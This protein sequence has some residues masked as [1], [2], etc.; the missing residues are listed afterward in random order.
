MQYIEN[1][2]IQCL[3]E[4]R[5]LYLSSVGSTTKTHPHQTI[6]TTVLSMERATSGSKWTHVSVAAYLNIFAQSIREL[7]SHRVPTKRNGKTEKLGP[8]TLEKACYSTHRQKPSSVERSNGPGATSRIQF[9][10][11]LRHKHNQAVHCCCDNVCWGKQ[12]NIT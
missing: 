12:I 3:A 2:T 5:D 7:L 6:F 8:N 4:L 11:T 9:P 1:V 10:Q